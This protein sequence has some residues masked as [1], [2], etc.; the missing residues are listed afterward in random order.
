MLETLF[1]LASI[2]PRTPGR[3]PA[4]RTAS[5][6]STSSS[7]SHGAVGPWP[8]VPGSSFQVK[9]KKSE[10][11]A[12]LQIDDPALFLVP[13][14]LQLV[15][16]LPESFLHRLEEPSM[17]RM[18]VHQDNDV[19]R[20]AAVLDR[21]PSLMASDLAS[22]LQHAIYLVEVD[23]AEERRNHTALRNTP[24]SR[25]F[26]NLLQQAHDCVIVHTSSDLLQKEM[27]SHVVEV[28]SKI[29]IV[30][31]GLALKNSLTNLPREGVRRRG[32]DRRA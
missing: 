13:L 19:V 16:L 10:T 18:G 29:Q 5:D 32:R 31:M 9:A 22:P 7:R 2:G 4:R 21:C 1:S 15:E 12:S 11:L 24:T 30:D 20:P 6:Y 23:V 14:H 17:T 26:Q 8:S 25:G 3:V 27:M 28:G